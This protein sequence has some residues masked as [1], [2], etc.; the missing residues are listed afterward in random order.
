GFGAMLSFELA[1]AENEIAA[2]L[3]RL[4]R[5]ILAESLGGFESLIA[6]PATMTHLSMSPEARAQ[7]GICDELFRLSNGLEAFDDLWSNLGTVIGHEF[8]GKI[9]AVGSNVHGHN[10]G[11]LVSVEGHIVCGRCRNCLAGRRH[12]CANT[13]GVGVNRDGAFAE[14]VTVP[15]LNVWHCDPK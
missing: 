14:Y 11:D 15:A 8:V 7:A 5:F 10:V 13:L 3:A 1:I 2:F 6:H 9:A 4:K 12:L